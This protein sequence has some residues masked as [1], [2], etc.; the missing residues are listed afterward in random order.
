MVFNP[1]GR[2]WEGVEFNSRVGFKEGVEL[3]SRGGFKEGVL[4]SSRLWFWEGVDGEPPSIS[5]SNS[6]K[7][8][9]TIKLRRIND[10][11]NACLLKNNKRNKWDM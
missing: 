2:L 4:G 8:Y 6:L 3:D 1:T 10:K 9:N 11:S 5:F 7:H